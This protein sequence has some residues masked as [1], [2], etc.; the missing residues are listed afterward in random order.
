[1]EPDKKQ[2]ENFLKQNAI[3]DFIIKKVAGDAS[4]RSYFR[5]SYQNQSKILMFAPPSHERIDHFIQIDEILVNQGFNA[6]R[7]FAFDEK[8]GFILLEDFGDV[9]FTKALNV[10]ENKEKKE[11]ELK[12]YQQACDILLN[13]SNIEI[14]EKIPQYNNATLMREAML[15]V[16]WYLPFVK[17]VNLNLKEKSQFEK[18]FFHLF[19]LLDQKHNCLVLRDYHADNLMLLK[20]GEI[21][22]L[23]FQDALKG[24]AAYDLVSLLEDARRD[25]D[26]ENKEKLFFNY[27][28]EAKKQNVAFNEKQFII[29]YRIL[30]LQRNIKI[31]GVFARLTYR[32]NKPQYLNYLPRVIEFIK[33][34]LENNDFCDIKAYNDDLVKKSFLE[35]KDFLSQYI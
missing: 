26:S 9:T 16:D 31:I 27:L 13:L 10:L 2:L 30:S 21:G 3:H 1:M 17:K 33:N 23:D 18:L 28:K 4:F 24:L 12:I 14:T 22:L 8:N 25:I 29:D 34:R 11:L 6:P 19:D 32:D 35:M 20:N 7:I 15:F 5:I